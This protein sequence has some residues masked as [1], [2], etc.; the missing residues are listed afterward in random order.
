MK[1]YLIKTFA[2]NKFIVETY[3]NGVL[4]TRDVANNDDY[5]DVVQNLQ[6]NGYSEGVTPKTAEDAKAYYTWCKKNILYEK[7]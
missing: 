4:Q 5:Y 3:H 1:Q 2:D 7:K 6:T